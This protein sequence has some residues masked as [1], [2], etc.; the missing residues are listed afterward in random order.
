MQRGQVIT[1]YL[2]EAPT[3]TWGASNCIHFVF[4][5]VKLAN[6]RDLYPEA[7]LAP[8]PSMLAAYRDIRS[9][10]ATLSDAFE[11]VYKRPRVPLS[12]LTIG[13]IVA[14]PLR[15]NAQALGLCIGRH[16][17][18]AS[19]GGIVYFSMEHMLHGWR[20]E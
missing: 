14:A 13:D 16:A 19:P 20:V 7:K 2:M 12:Y 4:N 17:A 18:F 9:R 6:G 11:Q 10:A 3:F 5:W 1:Q 8:S 15:G